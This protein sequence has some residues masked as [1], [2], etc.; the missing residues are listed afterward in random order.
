[1]PTGKKIRL[2]VIS[3]EFFDPS[4]GRMGGF[5]WATRQ[6]AHCFNDNPHLGVDLVFL[7]GDKYARKKRV[8]PIAHGT[9]LI[10]RERN[11]LRYFMRL[12]REHFDLLL[13]ID[14]RPKYRAI[15]HV[16]PRTPIIVWARDPRTAE[17]AARISAVRIPGEET[18]PPQGIKTP[19]CTSL[20][21]VV[22]TSAWWRR[23]VLFATPAP[24]LADKFM[25]AY[26]VQPSAVTMLP[27]IV[28]IEP[29]SIK[30]SETPMVVF[31][32]RLD[33]LKRPWIFVELARRFPDVRFLL[34][35]QAHFHGKGAWE[36]Q[37]LP[38]NVE[39]T[40]HVGE[41]AKASL[42]SEAWVLV[43]TSVHEGLAVSFQEALRCET[44]LL[45]CVN[46]Q[47]I[48]SRFGI[49][50]GRYDGDGMDGI[51]HFIEAL[52][53]LLTNSELRSRLGKEGSAWVRETH[54]RERFLDA[55]SDLVARARIRAPHK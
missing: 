3:N 49:Y 16:L 33:P 54:T 38:P 40:G 18:V 12:W 46:P 13:S 42:L 35:G 24:F 44:P 19:D 51:P 7:S 25:D 5:G 10:L 20:A 30:K 1:M 4:L 41:Q 26:G 9:R 23:P 32:G 17:D 50:V 11:T 31:L 34:L 45:S 21:S 47:N 39:L 36:P 55:F 28:D 27:N 15:F 2:G 52:S 48:V 43:N 29:A 22:R 6:L 37:T 8:A 14:Y 53:H